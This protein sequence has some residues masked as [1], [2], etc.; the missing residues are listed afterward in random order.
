[1]LHL[2]MKK[3]PIQMRH[4]TNCSAVIHQQDFFKLDDE[5]HR[6]KVCKDTKSENLLLDGKGTVKFEIHTSKP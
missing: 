5:F 2:Y 4:V 1:M 3:N 6:H